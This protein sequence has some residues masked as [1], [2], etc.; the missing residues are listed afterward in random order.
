MTITPLVLILVAIAEM[1]HSSNDNKINVEYEKRKPKLTEV[2]RGQYF[3]LFSKDT[4]IKV[5][6]SGH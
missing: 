3:Y 2:V 1:S 4:L 6:S 5:V